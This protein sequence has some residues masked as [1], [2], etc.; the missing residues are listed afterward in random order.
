MAHKNT[1]SQIQRILTILKILISQSQAIPLQKIKNNLALFG[2][3]PDSCGQSIRNIQRDIAVLRKIG[4]EIINKKLYGYLLLAP[5]K[6]SLCDDKVRIV[7]TAEENKTIKMKKAVRKNWINTLING[8]CLAVIPSIPDASLDLI[9]CSPPYNFGIKYDLYNDRKYYSEYIQWL[10]KIF[11]EIFPKLKDGGRVCINIAD[12][13]NGRIHTHV[14]VEEFMTHT[15]GYLPLA[16]IIWNKL[17]VSNRQSW[18]SFQSPQCPSLPVP[19]EFILVYAK[20]SLSLQ[21][22][23]KSDLTKEEFIDWS[24]ALWEFPNSAHHET[25]PQINGKNHPAAFPEELATR[26][27]KLF[28]WVGATVLDPFSGSGTSLVASKKLG[29]NYIG[30]EISAEYCKNSRTRLQEI[31]E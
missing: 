25:S 14:D 3:K 27:I 26:L 2:I 22:E 1:Q 24:L 19:Y 12:A 17:S 30:I 6:Q 15:L 7:E 8:D 9:L 11:K 28:S 21:W 5:S 18:G 20:K 4:F 29:R 10:E 16:K 31:P 23:G 13:R